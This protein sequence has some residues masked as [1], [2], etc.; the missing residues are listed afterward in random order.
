VILEGRL[1]LTFTVDFAALKAML[2]TVACHAVL[3]AAAAVAP[4]GGS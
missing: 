3:F 2:V 1:L 4:A